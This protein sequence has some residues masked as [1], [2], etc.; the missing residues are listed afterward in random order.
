MRWR[1]LAAAVAT[2]V[3]GCAYYNGLYNANHLAGDARR[4]EREGRTGE[5]RSLWSRVAVKA[6]SVVSRYPRSKYRDDALL[7]QG[8]ALRRIDAYTQAVDPLKLAIDSARDPHIRRQARLTLGECRVLMAEPDSAVLVLTPLLTDPGDSTTASAARWW[9]GRA[10]LALGH[11][12]QAAEYF[13]HSREPDAPFD[14]VLALVRLGKA[15]EATAILRAQLPAP[16][17][18]SVWLPA[19]DSLGTVNAVAASRLVD[20]LSGRRDLTRGQRARLLL[21]DGERWV[22]SASD[23][24]ANRM[25]AV[26]AAAPDSMEA[27]VA[28]AHL[29]VAALRRTAQLDSVPILIKALE[30]AIHEGGPPATVAGRIVDWLQPFSPRVVD[31][32]GDDMDLFMLAEVARDSVRARPLAARLF[33][34]LPERFPASA[35]APK[36]MLAA[37]V[38]DSSSKDSLVQAVRQRYPASPYVLALSGQ[39]GPAYAALE[40]SLRQVLSDR[41]PTARRRV[42]EEP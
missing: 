15:E 16:Y 13:S 20:S 11:A 9:L 33:T 23:H 29:G 41:A 25:D 24:A 31:R 6:E 2:A 12:D 19:L 42:R 3:A 14:R 4:A 39:A 17:A 1:A 32:Q 22:D 40:D 10:E 26:I 37:A 7:L 5:A 8:V 34:L 18:D 36:A 21:Q 30:D 38:L 28:R 27:R 35:F